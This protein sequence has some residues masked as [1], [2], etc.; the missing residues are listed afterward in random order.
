[1]VNSLLEITT[2][3]VCFIGIAVVFV[4]LICIIGIVTLMNLLVSSVRPKKKSETF[5]SNY[6]AVPQKAVIENRQEIIA[7]VVA[8]VAEENQADISAI[9]VLSFKKL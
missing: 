9:R 6:T 3:Q 5:Q 7:A 2:G 4:G 8:A 1:M